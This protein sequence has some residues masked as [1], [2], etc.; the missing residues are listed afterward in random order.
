MQVQL[1][2]S[3]GSYTGQ[4]STN[5]SCTGSSVTPCFESDTNSYL[6]SS[7]V[8]RT[9]SDSLGRAV[10]TRATGPS[11]QGTLYDTIVY[12]VYNDAQHSTLQSVPFLVAHGSGWVDPNGAV[13]YTGSA[14]GGIATYFDALG[15]PLGVRDPNFGSSQE[16]GIA[17]P[18]LSTPFV[19]TYT[20]SCVSYGLGQVSGDTNTYATVT[21]I[22]PNNHVTVSDLDALGRTVY[23]QYDSGLSGGTLTLNEQKSIQYN[24]LNEPTLVTVTDKAPQSGQTITSVT[25]SATYDSLGRVTSLTDPDRGTHSYSYDADGQVLTDVSGTR[26]IGANYDLLGRLGCV[27]NATPTINATGACSAGN[28][29]VQNTYDVTRLGTQGSTDFPVGRLTQ[30]VATTYFPEGTSGTVT[31]QFQHDQRGRLITQN[32]QV[33]LPSAW[34]VTTALP[35]YQLAQSYNDANQVTTTTTSTNPVGQGYT[36]TQVYDSTT[37]VLTGLSNN[38]TASANLATLLYNAR[39]Q[40]DTIAFQTTTGS[41][42]ANDQFGYDANLRPTSTNATWQGGSGTSGTI[43]SQSRSY[44]PASNVISLSTTQAA[45]PGQSGSGGSE[46][47]NFCYDEQNRLV[48]AGNS[49]TQPAAGTGT[50]GSGTLSNTLSGASYSNSSVYTHLGQLWQGPLGGGSTQYQ[51]LYCGS[52][53]PHQLTGLYPLG[54][55]CASKSGQVYTSSYDAWGNVTSRYF[56]GTTAT[57]SYDL[58]DHFTEWNAGA[59]NQEWYLYDGS[60]Q[61]VLRRTTNSS[62]TTMTVYAFGLEEHSYS[63][64]GANQGNTY[65]YTLAGHLIGKF[66]GS[67]TLFFL[68]D[69]LG[70]PLASFTNT[71]NSAA[72]QGNQV[73]GPYG[74]QRYHQGTLGTSLGFAGQYNDSLT[75]LDYYNARYYDP[76]VGV[77]LSADPV[78][79]N[80]SGGNPY[81]YVGGNPETKND[82]TGLA[83]CLPGELCMIGGKPGTLPGCDLSSCGTAP[84]NLVATGGGFGSVLQAGNPA[85]VVVPT[86]RSSAS[87]GNNTNSCGGSSQV[88]CA[89]SKWNVLTHISVN[90]RLRIT[91]GV[92]LGG[93]ACTAIGPCF[94]VPSSVSVS[95]EVNVQASLMTATPVAG[96]TTA[97]ACLVEGEGIEEKP[98]DDA[99]ALEL[100]LACSFTARTVVATDHGKQP[101]STLHAGE[102][103]LAYNP[104]TH[105]MEWQPI[106]HV[107]IHTDNDLVDLTITTTTPAQHG[108]P[109]TRTSEVLHT[110]QK[111][112]FFTLEQGFLP[113][114]NIKLGMHLLR[115]D[116]SIGVVTAWKTVS[117]RQVMYNL[118][119][120]QDHTFTVGTGQ[121]VVHN[122][123]EPA[124]PQPPEGPGVPVNSKGNPYPSVIDPRTGELI[125][126]PEGELQRIPPEDR[127]QWNSR[128]RNAF[129]NEWVARG[130]P[131]PE[132]GWENYEIHHI[133]PREFGGT[134]DF[135]NLV[136]VLQDIHRGPAPY[137]LNVWWNSFFP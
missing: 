40:L 97:F 59:T 23:V 62:G 19:T 89:G 123:A 109:A 114:A 32:L 105:K 66:S 136:P 8:T 96:C 120:A 78:L 64:T 57:L 14:P 22:D 130:Y 26:T 7:A 91:V 63:S 10:E 61:R 74:K 28:P 25:T 71:A 112:P 58:L 30:S 84:S 17:C 121:W 31:E 128:L 45:V 137:G 90:L 125:P 29:Y 85:L 99:A 4:S 41:A 46:T 119:V 56:S 117:G 21:A 102:N 87:Q 65:Y 42:L 2:S 35:T 98:V 53:T 116:G 115:A 52:S 126:F 106:L 24:V 103:V 75:G 94:S 36:T 101:I 77:F 60:G 38:G 82:P 51:Y 44:D 135:W 72:V 134:N 55:T 104:K 68:T 33:T 20:T 113:V 6:Y 88:D 1:P 13:D 93:I 5:S 34:N 12:T 18:S 37:G 54:T 15:R 83:G 69:A 92:D 108:K 110:N 67:S 48:W 124:N 107:W 79:G 43:L 50:C 47:Q 70:T 76:K 9:F 11:M 111:H 27:Q 81:A 133:L 73:Y 80:G 131:E 39:A 132:G 129:I 49:G 127:V 100:G 118:E 3:S 95:T 16:P 122:C 86:T